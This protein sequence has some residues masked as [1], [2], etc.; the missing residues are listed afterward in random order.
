MQQCAVWG[1]DWSAPTAGADPTAAVVDHGAAGDPRRSKSFRP[2]RA[3][4]G[5]DVDVEAGTFQA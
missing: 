4:E 3:L 2:L 1:Y 5:V